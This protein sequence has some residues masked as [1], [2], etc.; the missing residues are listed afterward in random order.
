MPPETAQLLMAI[1]LI[2]GFALTGLILAIP[3]YAIWTYHKRKLEEIRA[4]KDVR[5][6]E[7]TGKAMDRLR[8]EFRELRDTTTA[9]DV[10]LD[11]ALQQ[12]ESRI[13]N[14]EQKPR[15]GEAEQPVQYQIGRQ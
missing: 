11:N 14:L 4:Q 2:G 3:F 6:A 12:L 15:Y 1:T 8:E 10:S 5:V 9:Y 13:E 7:E